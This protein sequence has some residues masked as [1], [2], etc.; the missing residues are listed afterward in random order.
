MKNTQKVGNIGE[1]L[2][3]EYLVKN[4]YKVLGRNIRSKWG[5]IDILA[6]DKR[7]TLVF[8]EVKTM[9]MPQGLGV[10]AGQSG[11]GTEGPVLSRA[12]GLAPE[13]HLTASKLTKMK[14]AAESFATKN[15]EFVDERRGWRIDLVA[16]EL[17]ADGE[18][19]IRHYENL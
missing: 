8:V 14:K 17:S 16:I 19:K 11:S 10:V 2:A 6:K 12:E 18:P 7:Q 13:D 4:G 9:T 15:G 1:N 5:E 3:C